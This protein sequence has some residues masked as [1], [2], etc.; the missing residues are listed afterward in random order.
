MSPF[1]SKAQ[2]KLLFLKKPKIAKEWVKKYG[3]PDKLPEKLN[4]RFIK[5]I[6]K[7]KKKGE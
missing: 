5:K 2:M 1:K 6:K 3:V 7:H 4:D